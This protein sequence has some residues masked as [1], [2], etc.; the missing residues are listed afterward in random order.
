MIV[1]WSVA[2][3]FYHGKEVDEK[4]EVFDEHESSG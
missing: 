3:L 2:G 4:E 1:T